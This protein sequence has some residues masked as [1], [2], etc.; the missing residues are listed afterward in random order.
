[1]MGWQWYQVD[2][3]QIICTSVQ[4]EKHASTSSLNFLIDRMLFLT[5]NQQR[6]STED[7]WTSL[8]WWWKNTAIKQN[9][10]N[11]T[12]FKTKRESVH[13]DYE[14]AADKRRLKRLLVLNSQISTSMHRHRHGKLIFRT[15][16][17]STIR[18]ISKCAIQPASACYTEYGSTTA[19][20][21]QSSSV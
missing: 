1:M 4:T 8:R 17:I 20:A 15:A 6:H 13:T 3:M 10:Q 7:N 16:V 14:A 11:C 18:H 9:G 12:L 19:T 2:H 5:P 21:S